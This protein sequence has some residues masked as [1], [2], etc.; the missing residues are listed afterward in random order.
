M[1]WLTINELR[2]L[3]ARKCYIFNVYFSNYLCENENLLT[4]YGIKSDL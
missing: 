3:K 1:F 2:L 4:A